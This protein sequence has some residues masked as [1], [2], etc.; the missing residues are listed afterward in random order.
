MKRHKKKRAVKEELVET[1][2]D[3]QFAFIAGYTAGGFPYGITWDELREERPIGE[4]I[5]SGNENVT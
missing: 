5:L 2:S 3:D 4:D 1:D